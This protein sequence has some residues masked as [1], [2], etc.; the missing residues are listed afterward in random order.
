MKVFRPLFIGIVESLDETFNQGYYADKVLE[1]KFKLNKKWGKRDRAFIAESFY[2]IVRWW[3]YLNWLA[4]DNKEL[5][6]LTVNEI[7]ELVVH[8]LVLQDYEVPNWLDQK[9][10]NVKKIKEKSQKQDLPF[11]IRQSYADWMVQVV[12]QELGEKAAQNLECQNQL[13]KIYLRVNT[14]VTD[15]QTVK[16]ELQEEDIE[17]IAHPEIKNCFY[18]QKRANVFKT[19]SFKKGYFEVQDSGSQLIA[20]ML[21]VEPGM[22]VVDAC[23][24]AGGKSL[25]LAS[26][27]KNKGKIISLDIHEWKLKELKKRAARAKVDIIETRA[28]SGSKVLKRL[29]ETAD[30]VLL[31]VPCSGLGVMKRNPDTKWKLT[32][33]DLHEVQQLQS[34]IL[35]QYSEF[36]KPGGKLVYATCSILPS[37]NQKQV[38]AFLDK[39]Q[40]WVLEEEKVILPAQSDSDGFYAARLSRK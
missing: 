35:N 34:D 7:E 24:G 21:Q 1:R 38:Q 11:A 19:Q 28:I 14:L 13:A 30:R 4:F 12:E 37:E 29:K 8:W 25:H 23:A 40:G 2:N 22:R 39:N 31:D 6:T 10:F 3:R 16:K 26:Y 20:P 15:A 27:M 18:L 32:Q 36:V 17:V 5:K 33:N 9:K